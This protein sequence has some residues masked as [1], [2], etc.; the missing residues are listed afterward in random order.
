MG[1]ALNF[2]MHSIWSI[3]LQDIRWLYRKQ[4]LEKR[5]RCSWDNDSGSRIRQRMERCS[6]CVPC[7]SRLIGTREQDSED[8][9]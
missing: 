8:L 7:A 5:L 3:G 1:N 2:E 9:P 6:K 4:I